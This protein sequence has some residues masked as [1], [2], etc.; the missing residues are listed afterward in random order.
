MALFL[1]LLRIAD[2]VDLNRAPTAWLPLAVSF[3]DEVFTIPFRL[4]L[5][6]LTLKYAQYKYLT[7]AFVMQLD[8]HVVPVGS[9]LRSRY[10]L[11][12]AALLVAM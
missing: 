10:R 3:D 1:F 11:G 8:S 7:V 9:H 4:L 6:C 2:F 12:K 5:P